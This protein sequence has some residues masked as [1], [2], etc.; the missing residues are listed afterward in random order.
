MNPLPMPSPQEREA[1]LFALALE[2]PLTE[3]SAFLQVVC[4]IDNVLRQR[5]EALLAARDQPD[6]LVPTQAEAARPTIKLDLAA[7]PNK[8]RNVDNPERSG[9]LSAFLFL[10]DTEPN[11]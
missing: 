11:S 3:R 10:I 5:L 8:K 7:A 2:K 6:N 9:G 1:A 4:G